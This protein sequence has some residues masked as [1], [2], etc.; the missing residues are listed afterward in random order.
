MR[1]YPKNHSFTQI[2]VV[3]SV[4]III[5]TFQSLSPLM[6]L[7]MIFCRLIYNLCIQEGFF[8]LFLM[9]QMHCEYQLKASVL[10]II[11]LLYLGFGSNKELF[12]WR[13][14]FIQIF[15]KY[16][17][18][19]KL[20]SLDNEVLSSSYA[21]RTD[22]P[23]SLSPS[24]PIIQ[25]GFPYYILC[26][27][28]ADVNNFL[29]V[30]KYMCRGPYVV[31]WWMKDHNE[32]AIT[33]IYKNISLSFLSLERSEIGSKWERERQRETETERET[34]PKDVDTGWRRTA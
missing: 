20:S 10:W 27:Y 5:T 3:I 2:S 4:I 32:E 25:A 7:I 14:S 19:Y 9:R 24:I 26:L 13:S 18:L 11:F 21:N 28:R 31:Y 6:L 15:S 33:L 17:H 22:I 29:L 30:G 16:S 34:E 1:N 12:H 23:D 8:N